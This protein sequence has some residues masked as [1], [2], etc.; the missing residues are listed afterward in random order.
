[1]RRDRC[2]EIRDRLAGEINAGREQIAKN[3]FE[4]QS[5]GRAVTLPGVADL[6]S[7]AE[8]FLQS[9]KL[10]IR[11]TARLVEPFYNAQHDH[12]FHKLATWAEK[13]FGT[14]A[15]FAQTIREWEP[16]VKRIVDMRNAVDHPSEKPGGKLL[17][18]NFRLTGTR[19]APN[20]A[21]PVWSL[22]GDTE[23]VILQDMDSIIE[24]IIELGESILIA[25]FYKL[26]HDFPFVIGEI[27]VDQRDPACPIR[28]R[29]TLPQDLPMT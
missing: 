24:G 27:P 13:Q 23:S 20:L 17:T 12:R 16:W 1:M 26:K 2:V 18:Q 25:L 29:V 8:A 7:N 28:F 15:P 11:E 22:S 10:A 6:H 9:A 14:G 21:D 4:F 19:E 3:G 5:N